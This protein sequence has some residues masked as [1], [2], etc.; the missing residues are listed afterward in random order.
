[1]S[2]WIFYIS[3]R[4]DYNAQQFDNLDRRKL[5][6]MKFALGYGEVHFV[7]VHLRLNMNQSLIMSLDKIFTGFM[8]PLPGLPMV[9]VRYP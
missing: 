7:C 9:G 1:L 5:F 2:K 8:V 6:I 4:I 3:E